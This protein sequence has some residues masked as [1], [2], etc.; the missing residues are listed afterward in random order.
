MAEDAKLSLSKI[1]LLY[2]GSHKLGSI[3]IEERFV[4]QLK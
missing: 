1:L 4:L 2:D 3:G